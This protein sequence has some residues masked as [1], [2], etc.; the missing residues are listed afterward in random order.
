[1]T[2]DDDAA[3][4]PD[5][6]RDA[7]ADAMV[8]FERASP[9]EAAPDEFPFLVT[10]EALG[11]EEAAVLVL[12]GRR[13]RFGFVLADDL[14]AARACLF[15]EPAEE[16]GAVPGPPPGHLRAALES[17]AHPPGEAR[18]ARPVRD[19]PPAPVDAR[20]T[21]LATGA[22]GVSREPTALD[23]RRA[24]TIARA[25]SVVTAEER[26]LDDAW[27][28]LA[29]FE[30]TLRVDTADGP[31]ELAVRA[32]TPEE[33][34]EGTDRALVA[35]LFAVRRDDLVFD[36]ELYRHLERALIRRLSAA[37]PEASVDV[38]ADLD[39]LFECS[40]EHLG[41][42]FV[43]LDAGELD[44]LL[45]RIVPA[46]IPVRAS[47]AA[48]LVAAAR[49]LHGW[50][51]RERLTR[52][53]PDCLALLGDGA[54]ERLEARLADRTRF[55]PAK[56]F[57]MAALEAGH[58]LATPEGAASLERALLVDPTLGGALDPPRRGGS[59]RTARPGLDPEVRR[60]RERKR[61]A[62]RKA[63]RKARKRQR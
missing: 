28:G 53:A 15:A 41:P 14:H 60:A 9:W 48:D 4:D 58:D 62:G 61:K 1:M 12:G 46:R 57:A 25:L 43:S 37:A 2:D 38:L 6:P 49:A 11:L 17:A 3:I 18:R 24:E 19:R 47:S 45:F 23:R 22:D 10:S 42:P 56:A 34:F 35:E 59:E 31:V 21:L 36:P 29:P 51:D 13:D 8:A 26:A 40:A 50:L 20:P 5:A 7:V 63:A 52:F 44:E 16:L 33:R 27:S 54:V 55:E 39:V 32:S 30:R